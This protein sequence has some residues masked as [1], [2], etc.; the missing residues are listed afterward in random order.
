MSLREGGSDLGEGDREG[1]ATTWS[2]LDE[3]LHDEKGFVDFFEGRSI[4]THRD[5]DGG[6]A[7]WTA[8]KFINHGLKDADV[9]FVEPIV[10]NIDHCESFDSGVGIDDSVATDLREISDPAQEVVGNAWRAAGTRGD[11]YSSI[12]FDR[13]VEQ[14][15]GALN[16][17]C[18]LFVG[19]IVEPVDEAE[20]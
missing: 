1:D 5:S 19:V 2:A 10:I 8:I 14:P 13:N 16:D 12:V 17:D 7:Y 4:F 18:E 6:K 11:F 15:S 3:A 20:A 9:H